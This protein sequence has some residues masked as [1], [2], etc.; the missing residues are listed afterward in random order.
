MDNQFVLGYWKLRGRG[1]VP[2][3]LLAYSGLNW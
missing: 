2:R 1:Q 3:L